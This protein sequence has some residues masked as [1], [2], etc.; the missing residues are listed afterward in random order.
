[1]FRMALGCLDF[2]ASHSTSTEVI[3]HCQRINV[4][5]EVGTKFL[6]I[7]LMNFILE[8][9]STHSDFI[10]VTVITLMPVVTKTMHVLECS[11]ELK[12][13]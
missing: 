13:Q 7:I 1:M 5:C 12:T 3:F 2:S 8:T 9:F 6:Y 10:N 11:L 4:F